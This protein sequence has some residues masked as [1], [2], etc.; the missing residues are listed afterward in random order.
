MSH[1]FHCYFSK[2]IHSPRMNGWET[3]TERK[4][5]TVFLFFSM[6]FSTFCFIFL[7]LLIIFSSSSITVCVIVMRCYLTCMVFFTW[8][9]QSRTWIWAMI[10]CFL[11]TFSKC[12][13][14]AC[15]IFMAMCLHLCVCVCVR[16]CFSTLF[17][18]QYETCIVLCDVFLLSLVFLCI[19]LL[20]KRAHFFPLSQSG[21]NSFD[22]NFS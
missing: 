13:S 9:R 11:K 1:I 14:I 8:A 2:I 16:M 4:H 22:G 20:M 10:R 15:V 7:L 5:I 6:E 3:H 17:K 19:L 12:F 18:D 21:F